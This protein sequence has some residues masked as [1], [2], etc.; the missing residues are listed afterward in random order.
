MPLQE[1]AY[2]EIQKMIDAQE[3]KLGVVYSETKLS[4]LLDISRTPLRSALNR[5]VQDG[6]IDIL[7]SRGFVLHEM[8][9]SEFLAYVDMLCA[10]ETHAALFLLHCGKQDK[11]L[12]TLEQLQLRM[13]SA[14]AEE[15]TALNHE[16]HTTLIQL[17]GNLVM[18]R[19][20]HSTLH[21]MQTQHAVKVFDAADLAKMPQEHAALLALIR[22]GDIG[23][24]VAKLNA[25][26]RFELI[27]T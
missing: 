16:F 22:S 21:L 25:H 27:P 10:I 19:Y 26:V 3:L 20:Y 5:L 18:N 13:E 1:R 8:T 6:Y 15:L 9:D 4:Q 11:Y 17:C 24:V 14:A 23:A 2:L 12:K 7:P